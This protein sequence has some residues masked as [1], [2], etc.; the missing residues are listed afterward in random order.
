MRDRYSDMSLP[1]AIA[2]QRLE[3]AV[4]LETVDLTSRR[5]MIEAAV[6]MYGGTM[7]P[8]NTH[9][10]RARSFAELDLLGIWQTGEDFE[11]CIAEWI[12]SALRVEA[13]RALA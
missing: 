5:T 13:E 12:K 9:G 10:R 4:A 11:E 2:E 8:E 6:V 1:N 7:V 3:I